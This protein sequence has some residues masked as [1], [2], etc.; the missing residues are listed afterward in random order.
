M[1]PNEEMIRAVVAETYVRKNFVF[2]LFCIIS[3]T[4]LVVGATWPKKYSAFTIIQVDET[5]ILQSLMRGTAEATQTVDHA[6]NAREIIFGEKIM[7]EVVDEPVWQHESND[8]KTEVEKER[9]KQ[10]IR[11]NI[12]VDNIGENLLKIVYTDTEPNRTF[13]TA[14]RVA[15]LFI[16]EGERS[17]SKESQAAYDFINKQVNEYLD[18]LTKVEDELAKFRANNPNSRPGQEEEIAR[19]ITSLEN[20]IRQTQLELHE[21]RIRRE[22]IKKQL[23]GEAAITI[24]Q[25]RENQFRTKISELQSQLD[26]L[27]LDYKETY[28]DIVRIKHQISALKN[29]LNDEIEK[30]KKLPDVNVSHETYIDE[31]IIINPLYNRLRSDAA[32]TEIQ[33]S[34]LETRISDIKKNLDIEYKRARKIQEGEAILST[35]TRDYQVNQEIYQDLLRRRENARVSKSIDQEQQ[36]LNYEIQE[37]AKLPLIPTGLRFLHFILAGILLGIVFPV[38]LIFIMLQ[39]DP[40]I[41]FPQVITSD[42]NI[43]VLSEI[44]VIITNNEARRENINVIMIMAGAFVV[45]II[46]AYVAWLKITG[47]LV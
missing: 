15:E 22:S 31:T 3:L 33:I 4:L 20:N 43:P 41:R 11:S 7:Q 47:V 9:I 46:F 23:S 21:A 32:N 34:T 38:G 6:A 40:R 18:K 42:L 17:K 14:K 16:Y 35:L 13:I 5:N 29:S 24:S 44:P 8:G 39:V 37:P 26:S 25:T 19:R 2:I 36:G 27:R 45:L 1:I 12:S 28:P 30:R 10:H